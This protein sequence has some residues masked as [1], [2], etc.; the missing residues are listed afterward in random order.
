MQG[1][2]SQILTG[3]P[4]SMIWFFRQIWLTHRWLESF[5]KDSSLFWRVLWPK[6]RN[7]SKNSATYPKITQPL[8]TGVTFDKSFSGFLMGIK[9]WLKS[10]NWWL[11]TDSDFTST[12]MKVTLVLSKSNF[13]L[14]CT[15]SSAVSESVKMM[16]RVFFR[17]RLTLIHELKFTIHEWME[18]FTD[19]S[20]F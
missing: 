14:H 9:S 6:S 17:H 12:E 11:A 15:I 13:G 10:Q 19:L 20:L 4:D 2:K 7:L 8:F 3:L 16:S 5:V 18:L 1:G